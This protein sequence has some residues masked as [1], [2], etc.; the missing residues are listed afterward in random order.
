MARIRTIKPEFWEDEKMAKLPI[1]CR[2][3]YIGLWNFSDDNGVF[4]ANPALLKSKI[5]PYD[6]NLRISEVS[7]WIDALVE[8]RMLVPVSHNDESYYVIRT[9]GSHQKFDPRYPNFIIPK[10]VIDNIL[11]THNV[12]AVSPPC[13]QCVPAVYT[14]REGEG[15]EVREE[16]YKETSTIVDAKKDENSFDFY[17]LEFNRIRKSSYR[18][19]KTA[20]NQFKARIRD[21]YTVNDMLA[22]L[23]EAMKTKNH[24]ESGFKYLTPEFFTRSTKLEMYLNFH[25]T[26]NESNFNDWKQSIA[27]QLNN[28]KNGK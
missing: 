17:I 3:F 15:E 22:A 26:E 14:I 7:K 19:D 10:E 5:F 18:G 24:V 27:N 11:Q 8:A 9:F 2:L 4:R 12:H 23:N 16:V 25:K 21:G 6:E 20:K 28:K 1:P 13:P